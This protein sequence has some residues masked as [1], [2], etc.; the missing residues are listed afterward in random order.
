MVLK[1]RHQP[2]KHLLLDHYRRN[3]LGD[4]NTRGHK[5][6]W[7]TGPRLGRSAAATSRFTPAVDRLTDRF[8]FDPLWLG[9]ATAVLHK[10]HSRPSFRCAISSRVSET[11]IIGR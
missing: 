6:V 11:E 9:F 4:A 1:L 7:A 5:S 3:G 8:E 2:M 10:L